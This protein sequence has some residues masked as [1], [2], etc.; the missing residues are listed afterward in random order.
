MENF[1]II[2]I[3]IVSIFIG[4]MATAL[5]GDIDAGALTIFIYLAVFGGAV[6]GSI[7][8]FF[9]LNHKTEE[10]IKV[11]KNRSKLNKKEL[12]KSEPLKKESSSTVEKIQ[13]GKIK[14]TSSN[15]QTE[16][17]NS[18]W[19]DIIDNAK[20]PKEFVEVIKLF[21]I[22]DTIDLFKYEMNEKANNLSLNFVSSELNSVMDSANSKKIK[23]TP[24]FRTHF[25]KSRME[26]SMGIP[27]WFTM[28]Y[29]DVEV[30]F[31]KNM[32][33]YGN[34]IRNKEDY[35]FTEG[36]CNNNFFRYII[37]LYKIK[38]KLKLECSV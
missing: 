18:I 36:V 5:I 20:P 24:T 16:I 19:L 33:L 14:N 37:D 9:Y 38:T 10:K 27:D 26:R 11:Y 22:K 8:L 12:W 6:F 1:K 15:I 29:P 32:D 13:K 7:Y 17:N 30:W 25:M 2:L 28:A 3:I 35:Y 21:F 34:E 31:R 4:V 23:S